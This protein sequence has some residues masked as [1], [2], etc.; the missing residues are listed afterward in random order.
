MTEDG[1]NS[2]RNY[3]TR[4]VSLWIDTNP[5]LLNTVLEVRQ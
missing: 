3:A 4:N 2:W 1:Y 5:N